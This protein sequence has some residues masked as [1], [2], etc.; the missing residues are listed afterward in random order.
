MLLCLPIITHFPIDAGPYLTSGLVIAKDPESGSETLGFH[1]MQLKGKDKLGISLHSRQRLWE[2]FRRSEEKGENLEAAIDI[3]V[4]PNISLGSQ[5]LVPYHK[6]KYGAIAGLFGEELEVSNC[7]TVDIQVPAYAEFVIE[8]EI[9]ANER[10]NTG[11]LIES[12]HLM[13]KSCPISR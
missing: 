11:L 4:H 12:L 1:R 5:A 8:G 6:G 2:Y 7:T 13:A 3:G 9:L 10:E